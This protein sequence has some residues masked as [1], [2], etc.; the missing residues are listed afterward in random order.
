MNELSILGYLHRQ[1]KSKS[2]VSTIQQELKISI[3]LR[4]AWDGSL[5]E[6]T[7]GEAFAG[8]ETDVLLDNTRKRDL[9]TQIKTTKNLLFNK[10]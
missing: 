10:R 5:K 7:I 4:T 8:I 1:L 6:Q 9:K 3:P 2:L